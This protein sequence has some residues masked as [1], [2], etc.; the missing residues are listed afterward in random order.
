MFKNIPFW[1]RLLALTALNTR[2]NASTMISGNK[3][4]SYGILVKISSNLL[5]ILAFGL[6]IYFGIRGGRRALEVFSITAANWFFLMGICSY[7]EDKF[8][9]ILSNYPLTNPIL[10]DTSNFF[11]NLMSVF[12]VMAA[13]FFIGNLIGLNFNYVESFWLWLHYSI[14]SIAYGNTVCILVSLNDSIK[15]LHVLFRRVLFFLSSIIFSVPE[16][17]P[18]IRDI[19]LFNPLVHLNETFESKYTNVTFDFIDMGYF[20]TVTISLLFFSTLIYLLRVR[21]FKLTKEI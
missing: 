12:F 13:I 21:Q 20:Y 5:F 6:L 14:F 15:T 18:S 8:N 4:F 3:T 9:K 11:M 7:Y 2:K 1:E 16:F 19:F 17:P 10:L